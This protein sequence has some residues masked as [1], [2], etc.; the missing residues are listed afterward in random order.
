MRGA[1]D[2]PGPRLRVRRRRRD[3]R[4]V[5][6]RSR[7]CALSWTVYSLPGATPAEHLDLGEAEYALR[8]AVRSAADALGALRAEAAGADVDDPRR[9]VE[10]VLESARAAPRPGPCADAGVAGAG[11]RGAHRRDH[12][13]ELGADADRAADVVGGADR[14]RCAAAAVRG[15]ALGADGRGRRDPALGLAAPLDPGASLFAVRRAQRAVDRKPLQRWTHPGSE[16]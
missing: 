10:Q 14:Q 7:P 3:R 12:H 6:D 9:L 8:S 1:A 13:G 4:R 16:P 15:G 11:E 2:R 5:R